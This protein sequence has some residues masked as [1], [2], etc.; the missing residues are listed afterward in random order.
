MA[1]KL[2]YIPNN[3]QQNYPLCRL[4]LGLE[5]QLNEQTKQN[6]NKVPKLVNFGD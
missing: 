3:D 2:T 6:S 1:D 4:Q 5:T